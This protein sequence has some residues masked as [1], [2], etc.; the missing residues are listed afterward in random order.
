MMLRQVYGNRLGTSNLKGRAKHTPVNPYQN[1][2]VVDRRIMPNTVMNS[3]E[4]L[5][6]AHRHPHPPVTAAKNTRSRT[7]LLD[8]KP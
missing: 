7:M 5:G 1:I 3:R 6:T 4:G 8:G 2:D